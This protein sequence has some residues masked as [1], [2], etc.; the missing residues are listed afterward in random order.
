MAETRRSTTPCATCAAVARHPHLRCD[1]H[2]F[3]GRVPS[4]PVERVAR[5]LRRHFHAG[6]HPDDYVAPGHDR[7]ALTCQW[8]WESAEIAVEAM[9]APAR[10]QS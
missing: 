5:A 3:S 6:G 9:T 10:T 2:P 7:N 4:D 8:C 1:D